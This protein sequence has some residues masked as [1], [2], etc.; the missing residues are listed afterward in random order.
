MSYYS[1]NYFTKDNNI[2][3]N[4]E[5]NFGGEQSAIINSKSYYI[6]TPDLTSLFDNYNNCS[7]G[8][9]TCIKHILKFKSNID[10]KNCKAGANI[11]NIIPIYEDYDEGCGI[12]NYKTCSVLPINKEE[13]Y[14]PS[15]FYFRNNNYDEWNNGDGLNSLLS[16]QTI[17]YSSFTEECGQLSF[18][19]TDHINDVLNGVIVQPRGYIFTNS[20]IASEMYTRLTATFFKP[21]IESF[22]TCNINDDY[23]ILGYSGDTRFFLDIKNNQ[24]INSQPIAILFDCDENLLGTYS[25]ECID[26]NIFYVDVNLPFSANTYMINWTNL[27]YNQKSFNDIQDFY[28]IKENDLSDEDYISNVKISGINKDERFTCNEIRYIKIKSYNQLKQK[29][30]GI[31]DIEYRIYVKQGQSQLQITPWLKTNKTKCENWFRLDT[32]W[33][34]KQ[35]YHLE[36]RQNTGNEI[37]PI[38]KEIRFYII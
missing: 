26:R 27:K 14:S 29:T 31:T 36:F 8:N 6:F 19:I 5:I 35:E 3:S 15:N 17:P 1:R 28:E 37:I 34:L 30:C 24:S 2:I 9:L 22:S 25:G 7:L 12:K 32:S 16:G 38:N 23:Y 4:S 18:D 20:G 13:T 33:M 10:L 11:Y 21:F